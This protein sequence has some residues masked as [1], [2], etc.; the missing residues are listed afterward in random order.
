MTSTA[1]PAD[2]GSRGWKPGQAVVA[3]SGS[4]E[5]QAGTLRHYYWAK[6]KWKVEWAGRTVGQY[7]PKNLAAAAHGVPPALLKELAEAGREL[8]DD[9]MATG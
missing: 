7:R 9:A 4:R 1:A 6:R 3:T 2:D 8:F 5:G